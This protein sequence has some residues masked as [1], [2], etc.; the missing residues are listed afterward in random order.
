LGFD[1]HFHQK[2]MHFSV[3]QIITIDSRKRL[4]HY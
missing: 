2:A 3:F 1:T 4:G